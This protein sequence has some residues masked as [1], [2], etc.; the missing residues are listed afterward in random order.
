[1]TLGPG[2]RAV[3]VTGGAGYIGSHV[4]RAIAARG[5]LPVAYDDLSTG[6]AWALRFGPFERGDI[7][8]TPRLEAVI[9]NYRIS[10]V[11]HLAARALAGEGEARPA[12]Y[13]R[14][15]VD[16]TASVLA[17]MRRSGVR[18]LVHS[19]TCA[20]YGQPERVPVDESMT[21]A[22]ISVYGRTKLAAERLIEAAANEGVEAIRLRYFN[23]AGADPDGAIGEWHEPESHIVPSVLLALRDQR[24]VRLFGDDYPTADGTCVRD[25]LHVSDIA[26]AHLDAFDALERGRH[27]RAFNLGSGVGNSVQ[28]VIAACVQATGQPARIERLPRRPGDPAGLFAAAAA[29][30]SELGWQPRHGDLATI[31]HTAWRWIRDG[32]AIRAAVPL[33]PGSTV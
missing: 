21:P 26:A 4:C 28:E 13:Q 16:G 6:N 1:M 22:P 11:A 9:R 18:R 19:S 17:A 10:A 29:A 27:G 31:V 14:I 8:D 23:V 15:N 24:P 33:E 12:E 7:L 30:R 32:G 20:V 3:L 25:Y 2:Q 5:W